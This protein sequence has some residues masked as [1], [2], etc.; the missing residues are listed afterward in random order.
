[1]LSVVLVIVTT[2]KGPTVTR[3]L[4]VGYIGWLL[5]LAVHHVLDGGDIDAHMEFPIAR[6]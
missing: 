1:M 6:V 4:W 5:L 2:D 3:R